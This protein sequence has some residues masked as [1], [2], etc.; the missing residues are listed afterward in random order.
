[1]ID[2][3]F[4]MIRFYIVFIWHQSLILSQKLSRI[5]C[6]I[7][8]INKKAIFNLVDDYGV[9]HAG[10]MSFIILL[11]LFPFI[12]FFLNFSSMVG[13]YHVGQ[14]F[15]D[16]LLT[17]LPRNLITAIETQLMQLYSLPPQRILNLAIVGTI[18]TSSSFIES[19]RT[20][21]NKIYDIESPPSYL[22]RRLLSILQ[23]FLITVSIFALMLLW[24]TATIIVNILPTIIPDLAPTLEKII[25]QFE[26]MVPDLVIYINLI[27][28]EYYYYFANVTIGAILFIFVSI[29]YYMVPNTKIRFSDIVPGAIL[30]VF[31]WLLCAN[32]LSKYISYYTQLSIIYGS[33]GSII[34]ILLF[35]YIVSII[36]IYGAELNYVIQKNNYKINE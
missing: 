26:V 8:Q 20:I 32:I 29:L 22:W 6:F 11:S 33:L 34:I 21:L 28:K 17:N 13:A 14:N 30:T 4:I 3:M 15:I 24:L 12:I 9:E 10:Y 27:T 1:M 36:F 16:I 31:G 5:I 2:R 7:Y 23:F 25:A 18:W 35:F 19:I